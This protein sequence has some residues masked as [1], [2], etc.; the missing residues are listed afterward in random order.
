MVQINVISEKDLL[1]IVEEEL[2][3][4][5]L[6]GNDFYS[7]Y[8]EMLIDYEGDSDS[9]QNHIDD[10][11]NKVELK[12][13]DLYP[14]NAY[15]V[16]PASLFYRTDENINVN[17]EYGVLRELFSNFIQ[18]VIF[19]EGRIEDALFSNFKTF[20]NNFLFLLHKD[21]Q[22]SFC[23]E[24]ALL[25]QRIINNPNSIRLIKKSEFEIT[26][27]SFEISSANLHIEYNLSFVIKDTLV[28]NYLNELID[29]S[30][31]LKKQTSVSATN[32]INEEAISE[33]ISKVEGGESARSSKSKNIKGVCL[34]FQCLF[35]NNFF[36]INSHS[37]LRDL[38][39]HITNAAS[40]T[41]SQYIKS[42][43][44]YSNKF[45]NDDLQ[46]IA[47]LFELSLT[48]DISKENPKG[49]DLNQAQKCFENLL[50]RLVEDEWII[51]SLKSAIE[52]SQK[53]YNQTEKNKNIPDKISDIFYRPILNILFEVVNKPDGLS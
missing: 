8:E 50:K 47:D 16:Y 35:N 41:L 5:S 13:I 22:E 52:L 23:I 26:G 15:I 21:H 12:D 39:M 4:I 38:I 10:Q 31:D 29:D 51:I 9:L 37:K 30:H 6:L 14:N 17:L 27:S 43:G 36:K 24:T 3:G 19:V 44:Q 20:R 32:L 34:I 40:G 2:D 48:H 49:I 53:F 45:N 28:K 46:K 11:M 42:K 7:D 25:V 1:E 33:D 18:N